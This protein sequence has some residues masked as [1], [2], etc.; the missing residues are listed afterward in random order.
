[1]TGY[2]DSDRIYEACDV[3]LYYLDKNES[4]IETGTNEDCPD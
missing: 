3:R 1:M 4:T 2:D